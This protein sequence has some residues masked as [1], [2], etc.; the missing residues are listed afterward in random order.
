[1]SL[2]LALARSYGIVES[3][4][5]VGIGKDYTIYAL[6]VRAAFGAARGAHVQGTG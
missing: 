3:T 5:T 4:K 2:P 6:E 1:M